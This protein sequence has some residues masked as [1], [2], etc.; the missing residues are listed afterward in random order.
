MLLAK[1]MAGD[2]N[3]QDNVDGAV[4]T[5]RAIATVHPVHLMNAY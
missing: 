2:H 4:T 1:A 3:T 5:S